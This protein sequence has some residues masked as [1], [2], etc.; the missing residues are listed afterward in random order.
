MRKIGW[1]MAIL[2]VLGLAGTAAAQQGVPTVI[3]V[4]D[5]SRYMGRWFAIASIPTTFERQCVEGTTADYRLL[6]NGKVE[7][8]NTCFDARGRES[9]VVGRAWVP[10]AGAPGRLKVSFVGFLGLWL[11][12]AD[13][14]I[15]D[16]DPGYRYAVVGHPTREFGWILSRTPT[17]PAGTLDCIF[18]RLED[19][20]YRREQFV[21]IDQSIHGSAP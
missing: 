4:V 10:D 2:M 5:L 15:V 17:L 14:W 13:Y 3:E 20:G 9:R 12:A 19:Q 6:E 16:L 21:R 18:F 8:V 11:F 7:V 1:G